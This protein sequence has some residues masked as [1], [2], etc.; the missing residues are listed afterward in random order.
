MSGMA[1]VKL[2]IQ[3]F[4]VNQMN[5][6][7]K[8]KKQQKQQKQQKEKRNLDAKRTFSSLS[9]ETNAQRTFSTPVTSHLHRHGEH[10]NTKSSSKSFIKKFR[11]FRTT[12][13]ENEDTKVHNTKSNESKST[14]G[15]MNI[16]FSFSISPQ[17]SILEADNEVLELEKQHFQNGI[18][19]EKLEKARLPNQSFLPLK[20]YTLSSSSSSCKS[21]N[22]E[23]FNSKEMTLN[24]SLWSPQDV[25]L[26]LSQIGFAQ[27]SQVSFFSFLFFSFLFFSFL[28]FSFHFILILI[29]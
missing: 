1:G 21:L 25:G 2:E 28:F 3:H 10:E 8:G 7:K 11:R 16:S 12:L 6:K 20:Q 24:I 18:R 22:L 4:P 26:Y 13:K 9:S 5:L 17:L 15:K 14:E 19:I 27:Y 23:S 29:K